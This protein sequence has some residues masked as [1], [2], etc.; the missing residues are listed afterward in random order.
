VLSLVFWAMTIV[1]S[2]KYLAFVLRADNH[3]EGG[4]I[5]LTALLWRRTG[6]RVPCSWPGCSPGRC[7][8]ATA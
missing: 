1:V 2:V 4:V 8:T 5:A 6:G 3:G 7:S